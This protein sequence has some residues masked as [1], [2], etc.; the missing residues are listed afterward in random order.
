MPAKITYKELKESVLRQLIDQNQTDKAI[1][2]HV[3]AFNSFITVLNLN[4]NEEAL[5]F[6]NY[7]RFLSVYFSKIK[8]SPGTIAGRKSQL[9]KFSRMYQKINLNLEMPSNF[10]ARLNYLLRRDGRPYHKIARICKIKGN[11]LRGWK[12]GKLPSKDF[13]SAIRRLE[14]EINVEEGTL[15]QTIKHVKGQK[16]ELI[17]N[18][19]QTD[20]SKRLK[21]N[22]KE[23]YLFK[24]ENWPENLKQQWLTLENHF[25]REIPPKKPRHSKSLWGPETT[26]KRLSH[27]ESF[28]G[29]LILDKTNDNPRLRGLGYL[30]SELD[31][32]MT[33]DDELIERYVEFRKERTKSDEC[34]GA[35]SNGIKDALTGFKAFVHPKHGIFR[36]YDEFKEQINNKGLPLNDYCDA[37]HKRLLEI[38]IQTPW[39]VTRDPKARIR[40][41]LF[42]NN[43]KQYLK[44]LLEKMK[45]DNLI[46]PSE[47]KIRKQALLHFCTYFLCAFLFANPLRIKMFSKM[48]F[49]KNL[50]FVPFDGGKSLYHGVTG[51]WHLRFKSADFKNTKHTAK[52]DYDVRVA[53]WLA[54]VIEEYIDVYRPLT[55]GAATCS[56]VFRP[57]SKVPP[58]YSENKPIK[59]GSLSRWVDQGTKRYLGGFGFRPHS[60][61]HIIA[62]DYIKNHPNG[63]QVVASI[64]HDSLQTVLHY[65][66]NL[67]QCEWF[68]NYNHYTEKYMQTDLDTGD[69]EGDPIIELT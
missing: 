33:V 19:D 56:Y 34:N 24:F 14:I 45:Q 29:Y 9:Q 11:T 47:T 65:Y 41:I 17:S 39:T 2:N 22:H 18:I 23:P 10:N 55:V 52:L 27:V 8:L 50:V 6:E 51:D 68:E 49:D 7:D 61:R 16:K 21:I 26:S 54:P 67:K 40:S 35:Y 3:S 53:A 58:G 62:Y 31:I 37:S 42:S 66:G 4:E 20:Y 1:Q 12:I 13:I 60:F 15:L 59:P 28:F 63:F 38:I 32:T 30:E 36:H 44:S 5:A 48:K 57:C 25:T 46:D 64:L 69:N 43:P